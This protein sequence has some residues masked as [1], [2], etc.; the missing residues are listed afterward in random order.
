VQRAG[1][2]VAYLGGSAVSYTQLGRPDVGLIGLGDVLERLRVIRGRVDLPLIVDID[3]GYGGVVSVQHAVRGIERAGAAAI[4]IEDQAWPKRCGH[5]AG[6]RVESTATMLEKLQAALE[7]RL[8]EEFLVIARTDALEVEGME[9]ALARAHAYREAGADLVYVEGPRTA[10]E[11]RTIT[12]GVEAWHAIDMV[13]GGRIP[14]LPVDELAA[15]GYR[16]II[17][18]NPLTRA[19]VR[20]GQRVLDAL[21]ADGTT[22]TVLDSVATF[23]ELQDLLGLPDLMAL[24]DRL[25]RG[26]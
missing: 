6:R 25:E 18:P 15:I 23:D 16:L 17:Y 1:F 19:I 10:D 13:E 26:H 3:T 22:A 2:K 20:V 14:L 12:G 4:Q 5:I 11:M 8:S 24:E 7:S 21:A 9:S